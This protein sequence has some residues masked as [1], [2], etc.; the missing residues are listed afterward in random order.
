MGRFYNKVTVITGGKAIAVLYAKE[1]VDVVIISRKEEALKKVCKL[2]EK[3]ISYVV[4]YI[5]KED[6]VKKLGNYVKNKFKKLDIL[7]NNAG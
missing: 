6:L 3:K 4:G 1:G 5:T 7:V 2:Y